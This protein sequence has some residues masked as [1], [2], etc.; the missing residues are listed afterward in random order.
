[1]QK[2]WDGMG[3]DRMG[4][5]RNASTSDSE[6]GG[7][8]GSSN[9]HARKNKQ[10]L[11]GRSTPSRG[12]RSLLSCPSQPRRSNCRSGVRPSRRV[13]CM[14]KPGRRETQCG[15][16][17]CVLP[18]REQERESSTH[19]TQHVL[20]VPLLAGK[21]CDARVRPVLCGV[22][23]TKGV[24]VGGVWSQVA[25]AVHTGSTL[26]KNRSNP[27]RPCGH[28]GLSSDGNK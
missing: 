6:S 23:Q 9:E 12:T 19:Q 2:T 27:N 24:L 18:G 11:L 1:M 16:R 13:A 8:S 3:W 7:G 28:F 10:D 26:F 21:Y 22:I 20:P 4:S 15:P 5:D 25:A 17:L 14:Y